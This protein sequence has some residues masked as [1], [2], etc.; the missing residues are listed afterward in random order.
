MKIKITKRIKSKCMSKIRIYLRHV[1]F[2]TKD[3][4]LILILILLLILFLILIFLLILIVLGGAVS[5]LYPSIE[6]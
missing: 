3:V 2:V 4:I 1:T 5:H 6:V